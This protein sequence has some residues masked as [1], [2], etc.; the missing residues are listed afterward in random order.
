ML[1]DINFVFSFVNFSGVCRGHI[2]NI[3][4]LDNFSWL[5]M[6][7]FD[8]VNS[9]AAIWLVGGLVGVEIGAYANVANRKGIF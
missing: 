5:H 1:D 8:H 4:V 6:Y 2:E 9:V 3:D 7:Q